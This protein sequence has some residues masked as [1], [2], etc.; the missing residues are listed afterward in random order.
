MSELCCR[1]PSIK[2]G[3]WLRVFWSLAEKRKALIDCAGR[4]YRDLRD[5]CRRLAKIC[6]VDL[7][8]TLPGAACNPLRILKLPRTDDAI[9]GVY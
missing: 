7:R 9:V 4:P 2:C 6:Y 1:E 8:P 5:T 3:A